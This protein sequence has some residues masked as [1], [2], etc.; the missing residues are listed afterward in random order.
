MTLKHSALL[1]GALLLG[2]CAAE[3]DTPRAD[4]ASGAGMATGGRPAGVL[5]PPLSIPLAGRI[6]DR[7]D[8]GDLIA[9]PASRVVRHDGAYT[10]HRADL[11]EAH[12]RRALMTRE[13]AFTTPSGQLLRFRMDRHVEHP[14]G[15]WTWVGSIAGDRA[16]EAIIT[17]GREAAFGTIGQ[18]GKEPLRLTMR[19][20]V[21]WLVETDPRII[22]TLDNVGTRPKGPDY[23]VAPELAADAALSKRGVRQ[24]A[25][26]ATMSAAS[27]GSTAASSTAGASTTVDVLLGYT[28]GFVSYHG[29]ESAA[30]TRLNNLVEI[31]NEAYINSQIDARIR[32][33]RTML[34]NYTDTNSN[35]T[36][37]EEL[38]GFRAPS[39]QTTPAAAFSELRA[40]RD[41]YGA[42][43]VSLVRRFNHAG[44]G[45]CGIAWLIG[46]GNRGSISASSEYFGYSIVSDGRDTG[47]DGK[48]YFCREETLAHELGHNM[49][50][51]HDRDTADGDDNVL[52][53]N[54]YGVFP[55]S[56]GYKA[57]STAGNF[58]TVMAYG[59]SG[60]T[61]YRAFSNPRITFC[62]GLA[63]G[64]PDQADNARSIAGTVAAIASFRPTVVVNP[65]PSANRSDDVDGDGISDLVWRNEASGQLE[66]WLMNGV[67]L[68]SARGFALPYGYR[69]M[70]RGDF[71]GDGKLDLLLYGNGR[72]LVMWFGTSMGFNAQSLG[73][74]FG[75]GWT[76]S[77]LDVNG[78]GRSDLLWRNDTTGQFE[79]WIM[80]GAT[81]ASAHGFQLQ[82]GY[83]I[84][85]VGDFNG[86]RKSD[87]VLANGAR[88]LVM[89]FGT[90]TSFNGLSMGRIYTPGWRVSGGADVNGDGK[91]DLIWIN[92]GA[93]Q[94][95]TWVMDSATLVTAKGYQ[96]GAGYRL[97]AHGDYNGDGL[98][99][100]FLSG[101]GRD[102]VMWFGT[103]DG[104]NGQALNR[105]YGMG[106]ETGP[107]MGYGSP[108]ASHDFN[109]DGISDLLWQAD[110]PE[111]FEVWMM[112]STTLKS[113]KEYMLPSGS[114]LLAIGDFDGD[115]R[116][117]L[118]IGSASRELVMWMNTGNS[119]FPVA[120]NRFY[121]AGWTV[122]SGI[123]LNADGK[124]DLIWR[125]NATGQFETWIMDGPRLHAARGFQLGGGYSISTVGDFNRDGFGDLLLA[126][127]S[128][129]LV[130][131]FGD[132]STFSGR[133]LGRTYGTGWVPA[134][135]LDFNSDARSDLL[136]RSDATSQFEAWLMD[137]ATLNAARGYQLPPGYRV[138]GS[139]DFNGDR[140]TDLFLSGPGRD[141]V[142][143]LGNGDGSFSGVS[144]DRTYGVGWTLA[145]SF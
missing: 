91:S 135:I 17:F 94:F 73:R 23:I 44:N 97:L 11:S 62:G 58:F 20:G 99:D 26:T 105:V 39:T 37:L 116:D 124:S 101:P 56:F 3:H 25:S 117:D 126:N 140:R 88:E 100:V 96:L 134:G 8:R 59:D 90:G 4:A 83:K 5:A 142:M 123:D 36:A 47:S 46:G 22:A 28:P 68:N 137:G 104:F 106:W 49:G 119:F 70:S 71:N 16:Q 77:E 12:A 67:S 92:D 75:T 138:I 19:D 64:V 21:S 52:Q 121:G 103:G 45:G 48:T 32:L 72:D 98:A 143:W 120:L 51:Q 7:P 6:G 85:A 15:D 129:E 29:G 109:G 43:L 81:L 76:A 57:G 139:G 65:S 38:T 60:Q 112:E 87:L 69:V 63:C 42:D 131:W 2:A 113:A 13:L 55:Y 132:G 133:A 118:L 30:I 145:N 95:E 54:E 33:V 102:Q 27:S 141:Q 40:A 53:T 122:S 107:Q 82:S 34:V 74:S 128:R 41:Q 66:T 18:P 31:T 84:L 35:N 86:D 24:A 93:S 125:D 78:D 14:S 79:T 10:W 61:R 127:S 1:A 110:V 130:M 115:R 136:W 144:L 114:R 80:D 50:S 89:W 111:R 9:Y 108:R